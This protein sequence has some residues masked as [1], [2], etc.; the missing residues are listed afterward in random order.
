MKQ[1]VS[2]FFG[3]CVEI[4][5]GLLISIAVVFCGILVAIGVIALALIVPA[6]VGGIAIASEQSFTY[7]FSELLDNIGKSF[8]KTKDE[9]IEE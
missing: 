3:V 7:T 2:L 1:L 6:I 5:F 8:D 9:E 4:M